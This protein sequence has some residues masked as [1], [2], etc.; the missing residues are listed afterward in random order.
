MD[1]EKT[2]IASNGWFNHV[3]NPIKLYNIKITRE[4]T[5]TEEEA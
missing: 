1:S 2:F 3:E 5:H 4:V